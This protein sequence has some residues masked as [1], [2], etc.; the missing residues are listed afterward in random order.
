MHHDQALKIAVLDQCR[1]GESVASVT[2][3]HGIAAYVVHKWRRRA[4]AQTPDIVSIR[5]SWAAYP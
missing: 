4:C 1:M 5:S 3:A 2:M